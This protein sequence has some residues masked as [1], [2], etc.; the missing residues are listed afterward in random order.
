MNALNGWKDHLMVLGAVVGLLAAI[1]VPMQQRQEDFEKTVGAALVRLSEDNKATGT[2]VGAM[3]SILEAMKEILN[4]M[5]TQFRNV[6]EI[7]QTRWY[8][9][10]DVENMR[11]DHQQQTLSLLWKKLMSDELPA[12]TYHP[13]PTLPPPSTSPYRNGG[14]G[15]QNNH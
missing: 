11:A 4:E 14:G 15:G 8:W 7:Q 6:R 5:E 13:Y 2:T 1:I 10:A 3:R 12:P 9:M